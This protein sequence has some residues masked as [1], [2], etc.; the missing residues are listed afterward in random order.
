MDSSPESS[1]SWSDDFARGLKKPISKGHRVVNDHA[2]SEGEFVPN[3]LLLF[4]AEF[5][6]L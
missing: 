5:S 3:S 4:K 2:G 6:K 1:K